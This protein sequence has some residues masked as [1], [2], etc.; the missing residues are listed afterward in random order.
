MAK[1]SLGVYYENKFKGGD[2][3]KK[4]VRLSSDP[5]HYH[6]QI[7]K[8][9]EKETQLKGRLNILDVGCATGY[10]GAAAKMNKNYVCGV[11]ISETAAR[12]AEKVLDKVIIGNIEEIELPFPENFF[13]IIICS[14]VIEHLFDPQQV[15][16]KLKNYLKPEGLLLM[17]VPNVAWYRI[18]LMLLFGMWEYQDYGI[19]DYGHIR[20]FTKKSGRE[21]LEDCGYT[22]EMII[23]YI[24]LPKVLAI[25]DYI[26]RG[27]LRRL[28]SRFADTIFAQAFLYVARG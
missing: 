14:D 25:G 5:N 2:Y 1:G 26:L 22:V 24:V 3:G 7:L 12:E 11:E 8:I 16:C 6:Q 13:D 20:W 10:L 4:T 15:L 28:V 19:M 23:P 21:L 17:V 18:R 9:I 27:Y